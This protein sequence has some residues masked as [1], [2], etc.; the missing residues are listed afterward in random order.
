MAAANSAF[1]PSANDLRGMNMALTV[2]LL[3]HAVLLATLFITRD[4]HSE[5]PKKPMM[6][7]LG[8]T[9]GPRSTGTSE[10]GGRT[11]E[12]V[13]PPPKR[14]EP[15]RPPTPEPKPAPVAA[16]TTPAP[17]RM[18]TE[19]PK[20]Q[21]ITER[22]PVTGTQ[23]Q[24]GSATA[25]TGARG[26][27][28]GLSFGGGGGGGLTDLRDFPA[29]YIDLMTTRVDQAWT[30]RKNQPARGTNVVRFTVLRDGTITSIELEQA[31]GI[32]I[33]DRASRTTLGETRLP[34]LPAE[35]K[36]DT[37]TVHI[38]FPYTGN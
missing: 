25:D 9:V 16:R 37:L 29:W 36:G 13:A 2:S 30:P 26:T 10:L 6:I 17:P 14:L 33:L 21:T 7:T 1:Q 22:P 35:Y 5:P 15:A 23:V 27:S 19:T 32:G 20:P 28:S 34:P 8:G 11:V 31:S 12:Q 18:V 3:I 38:T 4:W 24:R